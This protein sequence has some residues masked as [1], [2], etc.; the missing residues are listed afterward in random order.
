[1]LV[2]LLMKQVNKNT[3]KTWFVSGISREQNQRNFWP[4]AIYCLNSSAYFHSKTRLIWAHTTASISMVSG[5]WSN[6]CFQT[7]KL[8]FTNVILAEPELRWLLS[9][10]KKWGRVCKSRVEGRGNSCVD[11]KESR[12]GAALMCTRIY[13][14]QCS[15]S[16]M[17]VYAD[18]FVSPL[19]SM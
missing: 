16:Y 10:G 8:M 5:A 1:M 12:Q 17:W 18:A 7:F 11:D 3:G 2:R 9:G 13:A 4:G 14:Q 15:C 6:F 19:K